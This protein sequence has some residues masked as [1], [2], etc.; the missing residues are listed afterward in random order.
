MS[1]WHWLIHLGMRAPG[2]D[3]WA[4]YLFSDLVE[5]VDDLLVACFP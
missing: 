1:S 4:F 3:V 2:F 5:V